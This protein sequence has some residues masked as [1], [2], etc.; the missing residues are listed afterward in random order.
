MTI[1]MS[2]AGV[3]PYFSGKPR[4]ALIENLVAFF[5]RL[6]L[7]AKRVIVIIE[8]RHGKRFL[9]VVT[10]LNSVMVDPIQIFILVFVADSFL[11]EF[12]I[13]KKVTCHVWATLKASN[14]RLL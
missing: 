9:R 2:V 10:G 11:W 6:L 14:V 13:D 1:V 3:H 4:I 8:S 7:P 5:R 12:C